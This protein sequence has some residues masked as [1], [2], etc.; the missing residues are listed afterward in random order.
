[1]PIALCTF[2]YAILIMHFLNALRKMRIGSPYLLCIRKFNDNG[3]HGAFKG[4][5]QRDVS[6]DIK[7]IHWRIRRSP[8]HFKRTPGERESQ[9]L[10]GYQDISKVF[11]RDPMRFQAIREVLGAFKEVSGAPQR[12]HGIT[13]S[14]RGAQGRFRCVSRGLMGFQGV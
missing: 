10:S 8:E 11:R 5:N 6:G 7:W 13:G 9:G 4:G 2:N 1:M 14:F 3:S 12:Y